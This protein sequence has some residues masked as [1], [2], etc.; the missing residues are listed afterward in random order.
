MKNIFQTLFEALKGDHMCTMNCLIYF[1]L[2][3]RI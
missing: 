2:M 3:L 1:H